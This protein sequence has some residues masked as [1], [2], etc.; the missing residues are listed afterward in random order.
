MQTGKASQILLLSSKFVSKDKPLTGLAELAFQ[1]LL[2]SSPVP[3]N[4]AEGAGYS[5]REEGWSFGLSATD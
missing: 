2:C 1:P 4:C 3:V 5:D